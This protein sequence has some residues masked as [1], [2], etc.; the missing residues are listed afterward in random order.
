MTSNVLNFVYADKNE[1]VVWIATEKDGINAYNY[2]TDVFTHYRYFSEENTKSISADGVTHISSDSKGNLWLATY[3]SGLD[4]FDKKTKTFTNYNQKNVKGLG[5]NYNW[6]IMVENDE[7]IYAGHVDKGFSIVNLTT[8]TAVNFQHDPDNPNSLSDNTVTSIFKDSLG[9]IWIGTRNGLSLFDP[10]NYRIKNFK[11]DPDNQKSLSLNFIQRIAETKDHKLWIGT[12]GGGVNILDLSKFSRNQKTKDIQ[13]DHIYASN[14]PD[15]LS[16][17]SIQSIFQ[18]SYGN[19]WIG[20]LGGGLNFIPKEEPF[21]KKIS[22]LPFIDNTNSLYDGSV[23]NICPGNNQDI[24]L[25]NSGGGVSIYNK[26]KK[27]KQINSIRNDPKTRFYNAIMKDAENNIWI[28]TANGIIYRYNSATKQFKQIRCLTNLTNKSIY[29]FFEDSKK[30]IWIS[31]D[32]GLFVYNYQTN[33]CKTYTTDNSE[34][35][36]NIIR[37]I[38]ED[39]YGN[40]WVGTLIGGLCV[41]NSDFKL[42]FNYGNIYDFYAINHIYRD[43]KNRMLISSQNDLFIFKNHTNDSIVRIGKHFGLEENTIRAAIEGASPN[44][45]WLSTANGISYIN[46]KTEKVSNFNKNDN[47]ALGDYLPGSVTK[48]NDGTIYFGSQNGA[49]WFSHNLDILEK[50]TPQP[51]FTS[52]L[53]TNQRKNINEFM[54]IPFSDTINLQYNQNSFQINFSVLDFSQADKVEYIY[55]MD[56]LDDGWYLVNKNKNV[57]FRNLKPGNYVFSIKTRLH[58]SAWTDNSKSLIIHIKPPKWLSLWAKILYVLIVAL[59]GWLM[60]RFYKNQ[61]KIENDLKFEKQIRQQEHSLNEEKLKFFTNITHELRTPMTLILGPL[62]DLLSDEKLTKD[63]LKKVNA[64]Q[65]VANRLLQLINQI[66]EFRK[67]QNKNRKL[68]VAKDNF[69]KFVSEIGLKY[70]ELNQNNSI[71]FQM[72]LPD[73]KIEMFFDPEVISIILDNLISNAFKYTR[74]GTIKLEVK[75]YVDDNV[76]YTE[77]IVRDT[78]YGISEENLPKIFERYFQAKNAAHPVK[79]TGI[80]LALVKNLVELHEAEISVKSQLDMGSTFKVKFVTNNSYP[81]VVHINQEVIHSEKHEQEV[82]SEKV[83]LVIDDNQEIVDYIHDNL[84]DNYKVLTA[85]NGQKGYDVACEETPDVVITDVMM[86]VMDGIEM[87]K[88]MK[89]DIRTSHIPVILLTAKGSTL[90]QSEGYNAGADSYLTKPFSVNLLKTRISNIL[91]ARKKLSA[92]YTSNFKNKQQLFNESTN[93]L[94]KE[95]LEKLTHIIEKNLEDE[96]MNISTIAS[97]LNM[98]HSTLYRKIK[99]LT[100]MTANEYIRKVRINVGEQLLVTNKYTISEIMYTIGINSSSYFR[101]CFKD[102]FGMNPSDYL[103]K[104]KGEPEGEKKE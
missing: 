59:I 30:N 40:I 2:K 69:V 101:Q 79:G 63:Q 5:S 57:T 62:E 19:M 91:K 97:Q 43:S 35:C 7:T 72:Q 17:S 100:N 83:I 85:E 103:Q 80:G 32:Y 28:G 27:I 95:F 54:D 67:T 12:E 21:F 92:L 93:Q 73:K 61:L 25:A 77:V 66:L 37:A 49:T 74:E 81:E 9:N 13:F 90:D 8:K 24:W 56:G 55:Q 78:G 50:R 102:E 1:D 36:D 86:P 11:N 53:I 75:N 58:N 4:Y 104:L 48:T 98:S 64:I 82:S 23:V 76:D 20:G 70:K 51:D 15:G 38:S 41:F 46:L 16:S 88:K 94:D 26:G 89:Q 18:D 71:D 60:I 34:L 31:T 84:I 10:M 44:E 68:Q 33:E 3:Q 99:A 45:I 6:T 65:N 39:A 29:N 14:T 52:F 47:I 22:H 42:I 87:M 96:E